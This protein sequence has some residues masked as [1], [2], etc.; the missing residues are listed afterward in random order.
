VIRS[1]PKNPATAGFFVAFASDVIRPGSLAT[2][3]RC[4]YIRE[5]VLKLEP[6]AAMLTVTTI[7]SLKPKTKVYRV[8]DA[9]GL[10]LEVH[11]NGR[12]HWRLRYRYA[13]KSQM[14]SLGPWPFTKP[15]FDDPVAHGAISLPT[16]FKPARIG[17]LPIV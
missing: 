16:A 2:D 11:P 4:E 1:S 15:I 14:M 13:N 12:R 3:L 7:K 10:C 9:A 5:Y 8:S 17:T 6:R